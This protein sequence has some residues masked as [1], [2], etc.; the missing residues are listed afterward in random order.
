MSETLISKSNLQA[1]TKHPQLGF[2]VF[3][4]VSLPKPKI[5]ILVQKSNLT[6]EVSKPE[7][8]LN[9]YY[10][11]KN[12]EIWLFWLLVISSSEFCFS[13]NSLNLTMHPSSSLYIIQPQVC[14]I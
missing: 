14:F 9:Q 6:K 13:Q 4:A 3:G 1:L 10:F 8:Y 2:H 12:L 5:N 11:P 7:L